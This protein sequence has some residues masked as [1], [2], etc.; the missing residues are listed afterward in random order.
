VADPGR[1]GW[2]PP[3]AAMMQREGRGHC[4]RLN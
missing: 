1:E 2:W 4:N 3:T